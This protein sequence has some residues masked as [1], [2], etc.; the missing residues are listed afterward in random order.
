LSAV[1]C[2]AKLPPKTPKSVCPGCKNRYDDFVAT[3]IQQTFFIHA[4]GN[5]LPWHRY[6]TWAYE[7]TLR[8]ECGYKG[9]QPYYNW[10]RW[11]DNPLASPL[12]DGSATSLGGNGVAACSN[13][14]FWG[15]P[16]NE[17]AIFK[18]PKGTGG[19]CITSGPF[20][21]WTVNLGPGFTL[22]QCTPPNPNSDLSSPLYAL[23]YNPRCIKRDVSSWVS[24]QSTNDAEVTK[25]LKS[26]DIKTFWLDI[27]GGVPSRLEEK[28]L[29]VHTGGHFTINGDPGSDFMTS[30]GDPYFY[31]HHA[32]VDRTWWVW[33]NLEPASRTDALYG[34]IAIGNLSA[35]ATRLTDAMDLG[36]AYP[37]VITVGDAMSSMGGPFCYTYL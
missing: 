31:F 28:I 17:Q 27:Q 6:F 32:Q 4:T 36:Y 15:L 34:S 3:H 25:V 30:P 16:N 26:P 22:S 2:L 1:N 8:N 33:Q 29:G 7:Q 37:G 11:S 18:I 12:L 13:Q 21:D 19:G 9:Q 20:K 23:G 14:T 5:F 24:S 35:Q 10:P